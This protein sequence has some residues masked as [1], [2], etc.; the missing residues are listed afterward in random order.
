MAKKTKPTP[1]AK[2]AQKPKS[3]AA[4]KRRTRIP[5]LYSA[6]RYVT[7][8]RR[9][10]D[11]MADGNVDVAEARAIMKAVGYEVYQPAWPWITLHTVVFEPQ[12]LMLHLFMAEG[13]RAG[14]DGRRLDAPFAAFF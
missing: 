14:Y 3:G 6:G 2:P 1:P 13:E 4:L 8:K 7:I 5:L 11:A 12:A 9:L 10:H